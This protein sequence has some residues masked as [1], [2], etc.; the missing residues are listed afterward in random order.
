[1]QAR[2]AREPSALGRVPTAEEAAIA[3]D[4]AVDGIDELVRGFMTRGRSKLYDGTCYRLAVAPADSERRWL[5]D[6]AERLSVEP[7][8]AATA[9]AAADA[10]ITGTAAELYLAL[11][12]RGDEV[13]AAGRPD[14]LDRWRASQRVTWN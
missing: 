10:T 8:D 3:P 11:W 9:I 4:V 7:D 14:V 12:N 13:H 1:M 2:I 6:V 5:L